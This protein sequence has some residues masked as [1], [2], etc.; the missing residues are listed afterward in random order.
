MDFSAA[1]LLLKDGKRVARTGWN[2]KGMWVE[3]Q[4]PLDESSKMTL[5]YLFLSYPVDA[6]QT[7]GAR[8]PWLASQTD[9][10]A[11]DWILVLHGSEPEVTLVDEVA[12][13]M[14][15][16]LS[17]NPI[18]P[19]VDCKPF[20]REILLKVADWLEQR[21]GGDSLWITVATLREEAKR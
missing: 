4:R 20:A 12:G 9:L 13:L 10:L 7:P 14:A 8:V 3:L 1:L 15:R 16:Q 5:P 18:W 17:E 2:G 21:R 11:E 6:K 19:G